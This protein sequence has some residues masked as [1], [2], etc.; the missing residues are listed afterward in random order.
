MSKHKVYIAILV[1][2]VLAGS[3]T[4]QG[5][6]PSITAVYYE[7]GSVMVYQQSRDETITL[8][9]A[10]EI[11]EGAYVNASLAPDSSYVGVIVEQIS[12]N[13]FS[14]PE[15][16][17]GQTIET[18]GLT[19]KLYLFSL[20]SGEKI[21]ERN[22]LTD[23]FV[24]EF[25]MPGVLREPILESNIGVSWS[26]NSSRAVWIEGTPHTGE[27]NGFGQLVVFN[28]SDNSVIELDAH[29]GTPYDL[30][31][32]PD[33]QYAVYQAVTNFGTGAGIS[34]SGSYVLLP[35]NTTRPLPLPER[36]NVSSKTI[37]PHGWLSETQFV[38][39]MFSPYDGAAG[40]SVY[41]VSTDT[42]I[43]IVPFDVELTYSGTTIQPK[44]GQI[45]ATFAGYQILDD[46][47]PGT[48]LFRSITSTPELIY[49][50]EI[51]EGADRAAF[52]SSDMV[53]L[54]TYDPDMPYHAIYNTTTNEITPEPRITDYAYTTSHGVVFTYNDGVA[55][56]IHPLSEDD[57]PVELP[58]VTPDTLT[59]L[60]DTVFVSYSDTMIHIATTMGDLYTI[61]L[62]NATTIFDVKGE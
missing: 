41:D 35:D 59:W 34:T 54:Y 44:T 40:L 21:L 18:A 24:I 57:L 11:P 33:G 1:V 45:V 51:N 62:P 31:W 37:S 60:S 17:S 12:I 16:L 30:Y 39:S 6:I 55:T 28:T 15:N 38:F 46:V 58:G 27:H 2:L 43:D 32:S 7:N 4:A 36:E 49:Q 53:Y 9:T 19:N 20:P 25:F 8:L 14:Y 56:M 29:N 48:Y 13:I 52:I 10:D 22:T 61:A 5:T 26:P 50:N 23:D 47:H 3:I 42:R